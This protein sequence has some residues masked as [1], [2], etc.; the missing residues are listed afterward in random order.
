MNT[1]IK[2]TFIHVV[3]CFLLFSYADG[4]NQMNKFK[5]EVGFIENKGQVYDQN[6]NLNPS[7][8]YILPLDK[9]MNVELK[10]N[11]FSYDIYKNVYDSLKNISDP[12]LKTF[13]GYK[14]EVFKNNP[15]NKINFNRIDVSLLGANP[16]PIVIAE[17][18]SPDYLNYYNGVSG[19][20]G[21][22][23]VRSFKKII[24][25]EI[26][27]NIDIIFDYDNNNHSF[28]YN[29]LI[30]PGADISLIQIKYK[31]A[32]QAQIINGKVQLLY[33][34]GFLHESIPSSWIIE[35][36]KKVKIKYRIINSSVNDFTVG[37]TCDDKILS[38][39]TL[40]IDPNPEIEWATY[41]GGYNTDNGREI[42]LDENEN[43]YLAGWTSSLSA[44]ATSG[45]FQDTLIGIRDA[46]LAKF[47]S[48]GVRLWGTYFGGMDED[49]ATSITY[50]DSNIYVAGGTKSTNGIATPGSFKDTLSGEIDPYIAKFDLN[51]FRQWATYYGGESLD[52]ANAITHDKTGN[53]VFSGYTESF[54]GI[55]TSG[56]HQDTLAQQFPGGGLD[57][58]IAKFDKN[59]QRI[60]GSYYGGTMYE[61]SFGIACDKQNNIFITGATQSENGIST[62]GAVQDSFKGNHDAFVAKFSPVGSLLWG[63]YLGGS[64][65]DYGYDVGIDIIE[66]VYVVGCTGSSSFP[67]TANVHQPVYNGDYDA[68]LIKFDNA[69]TLV[70]S[71]FYG[72]SKSDIA[73]NV[74]I[75]KN[76]NVYLTGGTKSDSA[77]STTGSFHQNYAGGIQSGDAMIAKFNPIGKLMWATYYGGNQD[78]FGTDIE[79]SKSNN[80]Y[81]TGWTQS[82]TGIATSGSFQPFYS[83][84]TG[85]L[86]NDDA[87]LAKFNQCVLSATPDTI[88]GETNLCQNISSHYSITPISG[89]TSYTWCTPSGSIIT[90]GQGTSDIDVNFGSLSGYISVIVEDSACSGNIQMIPIFISI[91]LAYAGNDTTIYA[92]NDAFLHGS[93]TGLYNWSP[94]NNLSCINCPNPIASPNITTQYVLEMTDSFGCTAHDTVTVFVLEN[95]NSISIPN[96]FTPNNNGVNDYFKAHGQNIKTINGKIFNRWGEELFKWADVNSGWDGKHN[97]QNASEGVYFYIISVTFENGEIQEKYGSIELI[98]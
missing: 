55:A 16:Q 67:T 20:N 51:G 59:G 1:L 6:F 72:G 98:R 12:I 69:G 50:A 58:F 32:K 18:A 11:A 3:F 23:K 88:Y 17:D 43:I 30:R 94:A 68:F 66:D 26:Y 25:K 76:N 14:F 64:D 84:G 81:I 29:F 80:V 41:Y 8:K 93:G 24:Y 86:T 7:V 21:V 74:A 33:S 2:I 62:S 54:L 87:F 71:T 10:A 4:Q 39:E 28:K 73:F 89:S 95:N 65:Y 19:A 82:D 91:P 75:D 31:G 37:F 77:I 56:T 52:W 40:L 96:A 79:V 13:H 46:F 85:Y 38:N 92:G 27:P 5:G 61:E 53:I 60:W 97:G 22:T 49:W 83:P 36:N 48:N 34:G 45:S 35:S 90:N 44:I 47:D 78:D 57:A 15:I 70:W 63:T 9:G 42:T